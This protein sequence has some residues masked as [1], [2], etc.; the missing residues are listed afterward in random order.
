[1]FLRSLENT[2]QTSLCHDLYDFQIN[3]GF[4]AY[5]ASILKKEAICS[6]ETLENTHQ[7]LLCHDL[8]DFQINM[9]FLYIYCFHPEERSNMFLRNAVEHPP[10]FIVS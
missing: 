9:G 2:H 7:I 6:S 5:T 1:M 10:D 8:D 4:A 3:V